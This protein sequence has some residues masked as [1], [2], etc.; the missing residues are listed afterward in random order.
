MRIF[1]A[2]HEAKFDTMRLFTGMDKGAETGIWTGIQKP[3]KSA[4]R[5]VRG[6]SDFLESHADM[7]IIFCCFSSHDATLC[8]QLLKG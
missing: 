8:R 6:V 7:E 3:W 5:A 4:T 2:I 1:I